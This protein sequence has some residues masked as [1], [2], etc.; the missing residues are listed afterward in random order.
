MRCV[1]TS[2]TA[3]GDIGARAALERLGNSRELAS[4]YLAAE[5]GEGPRPSWIAAALF[6]LTGQLVL[7]SLLGDAAAAFAKGI[8]AVNPHAT[9]TFTWHGIAYLQDTVT[10]TFV[11]GRGTWVGGAWT[12]LAWALWLAAT[13]LIGRL[14]RFPAIWHRRRAIAA[15]TS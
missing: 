9:G 2:S 8:A 3:S 1:R 15:A 12:P 7:T 6:L 5:F 10:Y 13:I 11:D 4:E 14:W